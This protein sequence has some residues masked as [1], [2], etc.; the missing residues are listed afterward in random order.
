MEKIKSFI[1]FLLIFIIFNDTFIANLIGLVPMRFIYAIFL[2][3][4]SVD[5]LNG[6]KKLKGLVNISIFSFLILLIISSL[7]YFLSVGNYPYENIYNMI[8]ITSIMLSLYHRD[9][10]EIRKYILYT[11]IFS[12][13][14]AVIRPDTISEWTFR[15][16]GGTGDPNEFACHL[17]LGSIITWNY[18]KNKILKSGILLFFI[19]TLILSG[20][21]TG[22]LCYVLLLIYKLISHLKKTNNVKSLVVILIGLLSL[23][24]FIIRLDLLGLYINRALNNTNNF[25]SRQNAWINGISL[26]REDWY[27]F[28]IGGGPNFFDQRNSL[29]V[30]SND[31]TALA[32]HSMYIE[33]LAD[34]GL[35]GI[36]LL[37]LPIIYIAFKNIFNPKYDIF[38]AMLFM[39]LSLSMSYEK[40]FWLVIALIL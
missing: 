39:S 32:A 13:I 3:L 17:I 26:F 20:S 31:D 18:I 30:S 8:I 10:D 1:L 38:F 12:A 25:I 6:L 7:I 36:I 40:Y 2:I 28:L 37:L 35:I 14:Y 15:K 23:Y 5:A 24:A 16:T 29:M 22:G 19:F 11:V 21:I 9:D 27:T 34:T 33:I 4:F